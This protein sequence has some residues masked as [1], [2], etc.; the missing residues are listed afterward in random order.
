MS[1]RH[2]EAGEIPIPSCVPRTVPAGRACAPARPSARPLSGG[3]YGSDLWHDG[4]LL[5]HL[6]RPLQERRRDRQTER[7][8][9]PPARMV[10]P[11]PAHESRSNTCFHAASPSGASRLGSHAAIECAIPVTQ[12]VVPATPRA[13]HVAQQALDAEQPSGF[14]GLMGRV[15]G[16][17]R[18]PGAA[19]SCGPGSGS[20]GPEPRP[21]SG[22][23]NATSIQHPDAGHRRDVPATPR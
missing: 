9:G 11:V 4:G 2:R 8:R 1:R 23:G 14:I 19:R 6:I 16:V 13:E 21:P 18:S 10:A 20:R 3:V 12:N 22:G 15:P 5:D 7:L 17:P